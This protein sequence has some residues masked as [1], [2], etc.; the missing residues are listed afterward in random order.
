MGKAVLAIAI[1]LAPLLGPSYVTVG[2]SPDGRHL[3]TTG[4]GLPVKIWELSSGKEVRG[5]A[6]KTTWANRAIYLP[7]GKVLIAGD[8]DGKIRRYS[9]ADGAPAGEALGEAQGP[10]PWTTPSPDGKLLA[11]PCSGGIEVRNLETS[12]T[13]GKFPSPTDIIWSVSFSADGKRMAAAFYDTSVHVWN[14]ETGRE[15][16]SFTT[17]EQAYAMAL[18]PDGK[19]IVCGTHLGI[20]TF[21]DAEKGTWKYTL[22]HSTGS[23]MGVAYSPDGKRLA[24]VSFDGITRIWDTATVLELRTL[25]GGSGTVAFSP[26]GKTLA[27]GGHLDL[28]TVWVWDVAT[29]KEL[30]KLSLQ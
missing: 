22:N 3:V 13:V 6:D 4:V 20:L 12:A 7:D 5:F 2:F 16:L 30:L 10:V 15:T 19:T 27:A 21:W 29:G 23:V 18:S 9:A 24:S 14:L 1:I 11:L 17:R 8:K 28:K 26:D 25:R